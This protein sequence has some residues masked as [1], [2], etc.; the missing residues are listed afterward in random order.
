[1]DFLEGR[2]VKFV[3]TLHSHLEFGHV[4]IISGI[5][6]KNAEHFILNFMSDK[7]SSDIPLHMNVVFG[8]REQIIRNTKI[9]GE[10]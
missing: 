10:I 5:T 2:M 9:N 7:T 6:K 8:E 1:M 3:G 4:V